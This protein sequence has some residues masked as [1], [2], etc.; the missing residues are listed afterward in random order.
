LPSRGV[1][2][3]SILVSLVAITGRK[4]TSGNEQVMSKNEGVSSEKQMQTSVKRSNRTALAFTSLGLAIAFASNLFVTCASQCVFPMQYSWKWM[5]VGILL[6][7]LAG[8][9][10]HFKVLSGEYSE[11]IV[12]LAAAFIVPFVIPLASALFELL[13]LSV[14]VSLFVS[15]LDW[16]S[17]KGERVQKLVL[18]GVTICFVVGAVVY[19][20]YE[21]LSMDW[22][23]YLL[24]IASIG[25]GGSIVVRSVKRE[26]IK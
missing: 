2:I 15:D 10:R 3:R 17:R 25:V 7:L 1:C 16:L 18:S 8:V 6:L 5:T 14:A 22:W 24:M 20:S 21:G 23:R 13:F 26:E 12:L 9:G 11:Q 4:I 19:V